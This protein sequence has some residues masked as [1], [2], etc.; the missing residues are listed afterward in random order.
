VP[1][2]SIIKIAVGGAGQGTKSI[3]PCRGE[4]Y[5]LPSA[6]GW[7]GRR[8]RTV[9]SHNFPK[10]RAG[11]PLPGAPSRPEKSPKTVNY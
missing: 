10:M 5:Q 4:R 8:A 11:N 7:I 3:I 2:F 9:S 6:L 1:P